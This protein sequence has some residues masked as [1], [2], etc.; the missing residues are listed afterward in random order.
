MKIADIELYLVRRRD[1][2]GGRKPWGGK[3]LWDCQTFGRINL[4]NMADEVTGVY[5]DH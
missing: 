2:T 1:R 3:N 5:V 4:E